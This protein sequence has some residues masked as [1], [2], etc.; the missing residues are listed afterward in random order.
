MKKLTLALMISVFAIA[1]HADEHSHTTAPAAA[2]GAMKTDFA[3]APVKQGPSVPNGAK[4]FFKN[5]AEGQTIPTKYLVKFGVRKMKVHP[6][7]ELQEGTG[8]YHIVINMG[9]IAAGVV[10]PADENHIHFG[11]GQTE[12]ELN[13]KPGQYKLTLQFADGAHMSYGPELAETVSVT[14][15]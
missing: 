11:K 2:G 9:P 10:V 4:V 6:A 13:L 8:H 3:G 14:V 1:A 15:K 12:Y 5:L 7:G